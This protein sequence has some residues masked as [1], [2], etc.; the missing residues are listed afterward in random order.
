MKGKTFPRLPSPQSSTDCTYTHKFIS[1]SGS[2]FIR[3]WEVLRL[4]RAA[5]APGNRVVV[6]VLNKQ[7]QTII[8]ETKFEPQISTCK[9][10]C[11]YRVPE[12][13]CENQTLGKEK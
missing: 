10:V 11:G 4:R 3:L 1:L 8:T 5:R 13:L 9:I 2:L 7:L 6:N 12:N